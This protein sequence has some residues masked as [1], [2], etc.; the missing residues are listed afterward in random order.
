MSAR[1]IWKDGKPD[2]Y[3][4]DRYG[5]S[6]AWSP[7]NYGLEI[8][9]EYDW[10]GDYEFDKVMVWRSLET[11]ELRGAYDSG[12]SCPSDF[13]GLT[14][15]GMK[16]IRAVDDLESLVDGDEDFDKGRYRKQDE[17]VAKLKA[18]VHRALRASKAV[19]DE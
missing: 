9:T 15:E 12:C 5:D 17:G 11:G 19:S 7:E 16:P 4:Y 18:D 3:G 2:N 6:P 10:A 1:T 14:W 8:V 13:G